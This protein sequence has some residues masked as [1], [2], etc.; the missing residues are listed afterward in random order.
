MGKTV[1][2]ETLL[3]KPV[4]SK[5]HTASRMP[6]GVSCSSMNEFQTHGSFVAGCEFKPHPLLRNAHAMTLAGAFWPR[7]APELPEGEARQF[8]VEPGT[9]LLAR[10]HWQSA[11]RECAT[12]V[13]VH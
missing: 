12:L 9:R 6:A 1:A 8:E 13:L 5:A 11:R 4:L 2:G 3:Q 7:W 10:C